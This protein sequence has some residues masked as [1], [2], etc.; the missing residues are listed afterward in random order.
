[1]FTYIVKS[2]MGVPPSDE[3]ADHVNVSCVLLVL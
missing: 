3:G 1:M 2:R